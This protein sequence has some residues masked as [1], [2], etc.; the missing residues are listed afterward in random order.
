[1]LSSDRPP[2]AISSLEDRLRSRFE[3]GMITDISIPDTETRLAILK[4][5]LQERKS[6]ITQEVLEYISENV[7]NNI[8]ELEGALNQVIVYQ[9]L[10]NCIIDKE[11]VKKLL[12]E[13]I[14]PPYKKINAKKIIS[15][16]SSF[17]DL[18]ESD[19]LCPSRKKEIVRPRQIAMY[20]LRKELKS[21][22]PFIGRKFGGRDHTTAI[23]A[24]SKI[25]KQAEEKEDL[26]EELNSIKQ[27]IYKI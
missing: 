2:N 5:K 20:L 10:N 16:V 13:M 24:V 26:R 1:V 23:Y 12:K 11:K 17:Y 3:G 22:F 18:R 27:S 9:K 19:L 8:R 4:V 6:N 14:S 21:S 15:G 7:K 25:S